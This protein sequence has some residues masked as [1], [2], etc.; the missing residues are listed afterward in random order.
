MYSICIKFKPESGWRAHCR[1]F[2]SQM[3]AVAYIDEAF[4]KWPV[5]HACLFREGNYCRTWTIRPHDEIQR[6]QAAYN[7][8]RGRAVNR[9]F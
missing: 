2:E 8:A 7:I 3:K 9:V 1:E 4:Q 5:K 6:R